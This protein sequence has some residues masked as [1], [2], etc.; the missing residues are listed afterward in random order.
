MKNETILI[1]EINEID[2]EIGEPNCQL[3]NPY[4]VIGNEMKVW[5][6]VTDQRS[7]MVSSDNILTIVDPKLELLEQYKNLIK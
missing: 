1:S 5:P 3:I 7:I 4:Q 6:S 2:V